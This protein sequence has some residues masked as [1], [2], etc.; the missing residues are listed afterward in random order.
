MSK[1]KL[2]APLMGAVVLGLSAYAGYRTYDAYV[3][4]QVESNLMLENIE[5]L[6]NGGESSGDSNRWSG[7]IP[8]EKAEGSYRVCTSNGTGEPCSPGGCVTCFC[9]I[10]F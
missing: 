10:N 1:R 3:E 8:C 2:F 5:A 9:G 7:E 4:K 6:A